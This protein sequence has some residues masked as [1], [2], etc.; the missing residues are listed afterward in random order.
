MDRDLWHCTGDRDQDHPHGK[1][2]QKSFLNVWNTI[3]V[4][5]TFIEMYN[6]GA[7]GKE[8]TCQCRR[9][10]SRGL[11]SL[12][13]E[14]PLEEDMAIHSSILAWRIPR[15]EEPGGLQS[16][17]SQRVGHDWATF[18]FFLYRVPVH[19]YFHV[20]AYFMCHLFTYIEMFMLFLTRITLVCENTE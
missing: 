9:Y 16:M 7:S 2:M 12:R 10:K 8:P 6:L 4:D 11:W 18:T 14:D 20:F 3:P 5:K 19:V 1:E 13:R 15:T 17:G